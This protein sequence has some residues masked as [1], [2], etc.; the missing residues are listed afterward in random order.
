MK[1]LKFSISGMSCAACQS[2]VQKAAQKVEGVNECEVNL[3]TN[4]MTVLCDEQLDTN[5]I[6]KAVE[7]A[8]YG[9]K[10]LNENDTTKAKEDVPTS[11]TKILLKRLIWSVIFLIPLVIISMGYMLMLFKHLTNYPMFV[12]FITFVLA[13]IILFINK[14]FFISGFKAVI[15]GSPNMDTLVSLGSGVAYI[16]SIILLI[17]MTFNVTDTSYMMRLS[18]NLSFETCGM[19]PTLI[20]IGKTLE[21]YSKG[22][23][24]SALKALL[25]LAPKKA[26]VIRNN[27]EISVLVSDVVKDDIFIVRAGESIAVDGVVIEGESSIDE[28]ML[29][30]ESLPIEKSI[31][32]TVYQGT[33]NSLGTLKVKALK[34][35][36][37]TTLQEI[38]KLVSEASQS[39]AKISRIADKVSGIFVP[40]VLTIALLTFVIWLILEKNGISYLKN[41]ETNLTFA[42]NKAISVLVISCPCALGLA[43]PVAIMVSSGRGARN[44]ILF[45]NAVSIEEAGKCDIIVLDKTGTI[46]KG[47]PEVSDIISFIDKDE[48]IDIAYSLEYESSH[49]LAKAILNLRENKKYDVTNFKTILGSGVSGIIDDKTVYGVNLDYIKDNLKQIDYSLIEST[50]LEHQK[51]GETPL[52]F[53]SK[54]KVLGIIFVVDKI[55]EDSAL[56]IKKINDLGIATV[57]LTGDNEISAKSIANKC[58]ITD[59]VSRVKPDQKQ[60]VI[61]TLKKQGNV[62]MVGDGINDAI[63]LTE[64]NVGVAIGAGSDVAID[65]ASIILVK[66]SLMD[67]YKTIVLSKKTIKNIKENLFWA[68]IYNII[69]IPLAAGVF[70]GLN[71]NMKAWYGA[72]A[73]SLSSVCV[74]L[75]A[76]RLNKVKLEMKKTKKGKNININNIIG[77]NMKS[78]FKVEGMMCAHCAAH[79]KDAC[80]SVK[81]VVSANVDLASKSVEIEYTSLNVDELEKAITDA[82]YTLVK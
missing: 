56:A 34:V 41:G 21:S 71:I 28:S 12:G 39:K 25:D 2:R 72:L 26:N 30:G 23:T 24:T 47:K 13:S 60:E 74:C 4:S 38:I 57:M 63:A 49:P 14:K 69:M 33:I 3:L 42:I 16:Y 50:I 27:E 6:I 81:G 22:K 68:F 37:D 55:K 80:L 78:V 59:F 64:A 45:K 51:E 43:T 40:I 66:S 77:E 67:L 18:M 58:N 19:V 20:T 29:T 82:G 54:E 76:L 44:G 73:M 9:A 7:K 35:G 52:V 70:I 79:V 1:K 65:S 75:N 46:T 32:D 15:H 62:L 11:E 17:I 31:G 61:K 53:A 48:L 8:G 10:S 5:T 36:D